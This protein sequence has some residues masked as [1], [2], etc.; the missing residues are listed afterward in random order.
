MPSNP[1][2]ERAD[3]QGNRGKIRKQVLRFIKKELRTPTVQEL[4]DLTGLSDKT[5]SAH[6]ERL[7]LG[8]GSPNPYQALTHDVMMKL[9]Q[10]ATGYSHPAVKIMA[11]SQGKGEA[12]IVETH[13]YTEHYPPDTAAAKL[14]MQL[15]MGF[16]EKTQ[17]EH[18]GEVA[19]PAPPVIAQIVRYRPDDSPL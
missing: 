2:K 15:V 4:V 9:Y 17:H 10:R 16:S 7:K 5:V 12:S 11:V 19:N 18:S 6:L 14:W 1:N 3:S 13:D 8:D